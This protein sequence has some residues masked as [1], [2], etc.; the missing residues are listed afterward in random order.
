MSYAEALAAGTPIV[1]SRNT[2]WQEVEKHN[3]GK[4][5]ENTPEK[6]ADAIKKY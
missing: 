5:V 1:A 6:F 3:C 4:W 2:P